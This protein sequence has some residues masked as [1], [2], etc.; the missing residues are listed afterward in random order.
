M[1]RFTQ[2]PIATW[3]VCGVC[4]WAGWV[5]MCEMQNTILCMYIKKY[6][7]SNTLYVD[8]ILCYIITYNFWDMAGSYSSP[9]CLHY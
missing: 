7:E 1:A 4:I 2:T 3:Y 6:I 8:M 5:G 9:T